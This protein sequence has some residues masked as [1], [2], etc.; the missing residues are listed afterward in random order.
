MLTLFLQTGL[1]GDPSFDA[2]YSDFLPLA[3]S[4]ADE[5]I[6]RS[7]IC[8]VLK[9]AGPSIFI[10]HSFGTLVG[11]L[12]AD[13]CPDLVKGHVSMEGDQTPFGN[14]DG[15]VFGSTTII[16]SRAFGIADIP[17]TYDPPVTDPGQLTKVESGKLQFTDGLLSKYPC[18]LQ[19]DSATSRP[20]KLVNIAKSPI[21]FITG[22][23][24]VHVLYDQ[25]L[26]RFLKQAGVGVKWT[27][28][29]DI[30]LFGNGHFSMLEKNSDDIAEYIS[31]WLQKIV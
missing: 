18:M 14:Y 3:Y 6:W 30:G 13:G 29:V 16:P 28:L 5:Y 19:A 22:Q 20:R 12:G 26:V 7:S 17:I 9:R 10:S 1:R 4:N 27:K 21:L 24:S 23:A 25:C 11:L 8:A 31:R 15:G 2:F